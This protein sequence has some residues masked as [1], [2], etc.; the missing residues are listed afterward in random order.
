MQQEQLQKAILEVIRTQISE[1]NPQETKITLERLLKEGH[2]EKQ[3]IDL[4][5]H[6]VAA[7]VFSVM[8]EGRVYDENKYIEALRKLPKMPWEKVSN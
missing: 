7:E 5:A 8:A 6:V 2:T 4:I 1:N 3:A